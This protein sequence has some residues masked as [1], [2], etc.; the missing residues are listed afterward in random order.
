MDIKIDYRKDNHWTVYIHIV[1]KEISG[2]EHDKYYVGITGRVPEK[3]WGLNGNGY[4]KKCLKFHSAIHKYGWHNIKHEIIASNVTKHEAID[5]E[6]TLIAKLKSNDKK[7]GYNISSGGTGGN[8]KPTTKVNK[9]LLDGTYLNTYN[10]A[11]IGARDVNIDRTR[12][13][14]A[15]KFHKSAGG[16]MWRY[17]TE[18][19]PVKNILPYQRKNQKNVAQYDLNKNLIKVYNNVPHASTIT[20]VPVSS[21]HRSCLYNKI[22]YGYMWKYI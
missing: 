13:S 20:G 21:I 16:Y 22:G 5:M 8:N 2:Y 10:S 9:Y 6:I 12:I 11:A 17:A 15:C 4:N 19:P 18:Y 1:P 14:H 3:R 7:Y